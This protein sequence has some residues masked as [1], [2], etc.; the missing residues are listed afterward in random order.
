MTASK[1]IK[2]QGL[3]TLAYV[4]DKVGKPPQTINNWYHDNFALFEAVVAGVK[5]KDSPILYRVGETTVEEYGAPF[6]KEKEE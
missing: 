6:K 1:Y 4:A 3:P 2:S 5:Y